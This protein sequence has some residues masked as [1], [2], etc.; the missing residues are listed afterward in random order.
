MLASK[1][2]RELSKRELS[3]C[4]LHAGGH[5]HGHLSAQPSGGMNSQET[6]YNLQF[7]SIKL[8]QTDLL[9]SVENVCA[10]SCMLLVGGHPYGLLRDQ[11][12]GGDVTLQCVAVQHCVCWK[13]WRAGGLQNGLPE[14]Q[15]AGGDVA[16]QMTSP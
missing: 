8:S 9:S 5:P 2:K 16:L 15:L 7:I 10:A 11:L 13:S 3:R 4:T 1:S 12:A 14:A 6:I